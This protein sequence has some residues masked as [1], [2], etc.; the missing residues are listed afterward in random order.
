[1]TTNFLCTA[2]GTQFA[3]TDR[4]PASCPI[5]EDP[6]Q[7]VPPGGQRWTTL[8]QLRGGH[9]NAWQSYE[10]GLIGIGTTPEFAIGQ[11]ALLVKSAAGN[12]LWDC[13]TYIDDEVIER[14]NAEGGLA[15]I[16]ISHPHYYAAMVEWAHA[17]GCPIYL[18]A[19]D[20][21]HVVRVDESIRFWEGETHELGGGLTLVRCGGHYAGA[22]VLHV[23]E[24]RALL[25]GDVVQVIPDRRY[26]G[27]MWS[28]PNLI[29]LPAAEVDR[30]AATLEPWRCE[31]IVGAWWDRIVERD[32]DEVVRRSAERYVR[33]LA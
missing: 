33:A 22:Q 29:P 11:R 9:R 21:T 23:A 13:T 27:F 1:M 19:D 14:V 15:A 2:C 32:G 25:S 5:C 12:L 31:R 17:F 28:Y 18:H 7:F 6:R 8:E 30:I 24:R 16:A 10:P 3:G 20:R 4:P 26:V